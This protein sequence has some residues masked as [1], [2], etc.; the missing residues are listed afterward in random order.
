VDD[1][2]KQLAGT[3]VQ[4][5]RADAAADLAGSGSQT[6]LWWYLLWGAVVA[7]CGEQVLAWFFGR[8]R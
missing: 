2:T 8:A 3:N 5:I 6:E 1:M 4:I 7:L